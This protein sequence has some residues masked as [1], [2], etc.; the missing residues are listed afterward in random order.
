MQQKLYR[1]GG[2]TFSVGN[3]AIPIPL[4]QSV[5]GSTTVNSGTCFR[6][7]DRVLAGWARDLGLDELAPDKMG[8]Y[9][10][11]VETVI[12]TML[13]DEGVRLPGSRRFA[14]EK[15]LRGEGIEIADDLLAKIEKLAA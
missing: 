4:G 9:F 12:R 10:E 8:G 1:R 2:T 15:K 7:P 6:T 5:G 14:S 11:R 13:A 3:V